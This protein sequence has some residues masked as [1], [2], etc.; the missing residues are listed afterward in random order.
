MEEDLRGTCMRS[1]CIFCDNGKCDM[2]DD[3]DMPEDTNNCDNF[4][5]E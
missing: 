4:F 2:W 1:N 3:I 5:H